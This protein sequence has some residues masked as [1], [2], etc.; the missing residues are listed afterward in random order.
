MA[1]SEAFNIRLSKMLPDPLKTSTIANEK[2][3]AYTASLRRQ[4]ITLIKL[5]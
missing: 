2:E 1:K 4:F 5:G 3:A